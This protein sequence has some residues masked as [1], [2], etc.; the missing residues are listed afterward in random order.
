MNKIFLRF[1]YMIIIIRELLSE[2]YY[3]LKKFLN[4]LK[5]QIIEKNTFC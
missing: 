3:I 2:N 1:V 4:D 5:K